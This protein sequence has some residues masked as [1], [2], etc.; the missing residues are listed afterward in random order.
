MDNAKDAVGIDTVGLADKNVETSLYERYKGRKGITDRVAILSATLSRTYTYFYEGQ[1]RKLTFRAP[2][3]GAML[4]LVRAQLGEPAQKFGMV[5]F[6]YK[7]ED[8]GDL[9]DVSKCQGKPKPWVISESR[10]E[11]LSNIHK[12]FPLMDGGWGEAQHD[13][14][15]TC[16]EENFQR[17]T[18]SPAKD[19]HWKKSEK[20]YEALKKVEL[21]AKDKLKLAMGREM[22][23]AEIMDLMGA[24][25]PSQTGGVENSSDI[26]LSDVIDEE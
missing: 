15:L 2:K 20:W 10:Y 1:N 9:F 3:P 19:S 7:T 25:G 13:L 14:L 23:D 22:T 4:E 5:L 11:E 21:K 18:F 26:D 24:S 6:Q 8:N 17:M 12:N 16:T